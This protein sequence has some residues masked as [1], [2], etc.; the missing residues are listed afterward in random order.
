MPQKCFE[1]DWETM[2]YLK[3]INKYFYG[4]VSK[5]ANNVSIDENDCH[6]IYNLYGKGEGVYLKDAD[7]ILFMAGFS[8]INIIQKNDTSTIFKNLIET[9]LQDRQEIDL[10]EFLVSTI[11]LNNFIVYK[12][13]EG[14]YID[15]FYQ[16]EQFK[17]AVEEYKYGGDHEWNQHTILAVGK[18]KFALFFSDLISP[19]DYYRTFRI[20]YIYQGQQYVFFDID[21]PKEWSYVKPQE[22]EHINRFLSE[23]GLINDDEIHNDI[24]LAVVVM[25]IAIII[26]SCVSENE[27]DAWLRIFSNGYYAFTDPLEPDKYH[28]KLA[29]IRNHL[30]N[31]KIE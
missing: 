11:M 4:L 6:S 28:F 7:K 10:S 3:Q 13:D 31:L 26:D 12:F 8:N 23:I 22:K 21:S 27:M 9:Y 30:T 17:I 29:D 25:F 1:G 14:T 18:F 20:E 16:I 19:N 5:K 15:P 24:Y 2:Y